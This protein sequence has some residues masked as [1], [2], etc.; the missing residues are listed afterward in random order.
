MSLRCVR[1]FTPVAAATLR[2][3]IEPTITTTAHTT[4]TTYTERRLGLIRSMRGSSSDAWRAWRRADF[5]MSA[6]AYYGMRFA[7]DE[8]TAEFTPQDLRAHA[9][10][11]AIERL[12]SLADNG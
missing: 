12:T 8:M 5:E 1:T 4:A 2:F 3:A 6:K 10:S 7:L 11:V 9:R